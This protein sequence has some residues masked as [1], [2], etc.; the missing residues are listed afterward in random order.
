MSE[1][2][3]NKKDSEIAIEKND[4]AIAIA[5]IKTG[6]KQYKV[7]VGD[8]IQIETLKADEKSKIEFEDLLNGK[9]VKAEVI[10]HGRGKKI[11][12]LKFHSKKRYD[13]L[14][15]HRQGFTKIKIE[16]IS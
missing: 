2:A 4:S 13:R 5:I 14:A 11:E 1:I 8:L 6:G 16:A 15:G 10:E 12:V 3:I 7:Q 9:K